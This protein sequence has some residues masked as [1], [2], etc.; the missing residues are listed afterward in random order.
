[1]Q[2]VPQLL[3]PENSDGFLDEDRKNGKEPDH[4]VFD[5]SIQKRLN[6]IDKDTRIILFYANR[7]EARRIFKEAN[8]LNMTGKEYQ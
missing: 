7:E 2:F 5:F 3:N 6:A 4:H 1:M 8:D